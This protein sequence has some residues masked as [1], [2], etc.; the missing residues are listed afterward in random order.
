MSVLAESGRVNFF[1]QGLLGRVGAMEEWRPGE[2]AGNVQNHFRAFW[3]PG[4]DSPSRRRPAPV[5]TR[6]K[7]GARFRRCDWQ[8]FFVGGD[9]RFAAGVR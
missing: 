1:R 6:T 7:R 5:Q 9:A 2:R 8:P 3:T 4:V